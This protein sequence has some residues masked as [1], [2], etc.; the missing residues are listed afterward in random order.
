MYHTSYLDYSILFRV[1]VN[2]HLSDNNLASQVHFPSET[3][4][5]IN[6]YEYS[7]LVHCYNLHCRL[8]LK[9]ALEYI[10]RLM[11]LACM[12][13]FLRPSPVKL[14]AVSLPAKLRG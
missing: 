5:V 8:K 10:I 7:G 1:Q 13:Q 3:A 11:L 2:K 9:L 4:V 12:K 14:P 6:Y